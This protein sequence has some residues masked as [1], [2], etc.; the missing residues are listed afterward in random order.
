M[1]TRLGLIVGRKCGNA[2]ERN[3][4]KRLI[5][6]AFRLEQRRFPD[7]LDV[8][9]APR[10]GLRL[11]LPEIRASLARL[12]GRLAKRLPAGAAAENDPPER[13]V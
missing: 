5:R 12:V 10:P 1:R 11:T 13:D 8:L 6:E 3:R 9:V 4:L 2:V 7:G